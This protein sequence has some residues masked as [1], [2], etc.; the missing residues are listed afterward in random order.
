MNYLNKYEFLKLSETEK[1]D[2]YDS[3]IDEKNEILTAKEMDELILAFEALEGYGDSEN[4]IKELKSS[5][6]KQRIQDKRYSSE[7]KKKGLLIAFASVAVV[8]LA[9]SVYIIITML[10]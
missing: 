1:T 10:G 4:L 9:V 8:V 2:Y 3:L 6:A 7:R 5:A